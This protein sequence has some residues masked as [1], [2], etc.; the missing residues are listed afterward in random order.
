MKRM[1]LLG[2]LAAAGLT[3]ALAARCAWGVSPG[4]VVNSPHN[5]SASGPGTIKAVSEQ[6]VCIFCHTPHNATP[7]QPLWNRAMPT[8]V[9]KPYSSPSLKSQP[10]QPTGSSKLCLSCHDG[11]I[12]L[13]SVNSRSQPIVMAGGM[14]TLPPGTPANLGTDLSDDHPISFPYDANLVAANPQLQ[15]PAG[16]PASVA[17]DSNKE[18][19][20]TACHDPHNNTYGN[21]L[22]MANDSSQLCNT[23]HIENG[24][25]VQNHQN[26]NACHQTHS[27]PSGALLLAGATVTDTCLLCHGSTAPPLSVLPDNLRN[28]RLAATNANSAAALAAQVRRVRGVNIAADLAKS[29]SHDTKPAIAGTLRGA[30]AAAPMG[31]DSSNVTCSDCH[32]PHTIRS[33]LDSGS[34]PQGRPGP[35]AGTYGSPPPAPAFLQ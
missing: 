23:C 8:A 19:Q 3:A 14:T 12:A 33:L 2:I 1:S 22:V 28:A 17:L 29:S 11:T 5:L 4:S 21:F 26:C 6:E 32:E 18:L 31:S 27:A 10:G 16:L 13:G 24:T 9:Y 15:D 25:D 34:T 30:N 20:C 7:V 35:L